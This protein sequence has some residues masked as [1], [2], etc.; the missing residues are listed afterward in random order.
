[1][2]IGNLTQPPSGG[3]ALRRLPR[4]GFLSWMIATLAVVAALLGSA[5]AHAAVPPANTSI[6]N[7]ANATYQDT[8]N[9]GVVLNAKSNA[10]VTIVS[11]VYSLTLT[12]ATNSSNGSAGL[13]V[14]Y[15]H[16]LTNTGNGSDTFTLSSAAGTGFTHT[17]V[18]FFVG[19]SGFTE[20]TAPVTLAPNSPYQFRVCG[21]PPSGVTNGATGQ[22]VV[23][24]TSSD[25]VTT[26]KPSKIATNTT[27]ISDCVINL[28]KEFKTTRNSG[29]SNVSN[30]APGDDLF[31]FLK[32]SN[33][34]TAACT[35]LVMTDALPSGLLYIT[36]SGQNTAGTGL[37]DISTDGDG[38]EAPTTS[39]SGTVKATIAS[40]GAGV[41]GLV[42]FQVKVSLSAPAG[43]IQNLVTAPNTSGAAASFSV[44]QVA[45]VAFN[46]STTT[47]GAADNDPVTV[48]AAAPG[49]TI[50]W[51]NVIW[52][53]GNKE[54][55]FKVQFLNGGG[56]P[57][58][59]AT[60]DGATCAATNTAA[61]ACT[62]PQGTIFSVWAAGS[63]LTVAPIEITIPLP[64]PPVAPA[65]TPTCPSGFILSADNKS[66]GYV[67]EVRAILPSN[68]AAGG[69]V[70]LRAT[71]SGPATPFDNVENKLTSIT[72]NAVDVTNGLPP[73]SGNGQGPDDNTVKA[74]NTVAP[75][76]NAPK[77]TYFDVYISNTAGPAA[78]YN[79]TSEWV[80]VPT[81]VGLATPPATPV[82]WT[83]KFKALVGGACASTGTEITST[84]T[85]ASGGNT[86]VCAEV[87][88]PQTNQGGS[89]R[90][91]DAPPGAYV[92]KLFAKATTNAAVSDS[93]RYQVTLTAGREVTLDG[94]ATKTT[95]KNGK[96]S[97]PHIIR[98]S[99]NVQETISFVGAFLTN[100]VSSPAWAA[101]AYNGS[102]TTDP[103]ITNTTTFTLAPN[104]SKTLL[105]SVTAPDV[106]TSPDNSTTLTATY[107]FSGA[108]L[109][110]Q[111]TDITQLGDLLTLKKY[112]QLVACSGVGVPP[113]N[114]LPGGWTQAQINAGAETAPGKCIA[115]LVVGENITS[116]SLTD[117]VITD[118]ISSFTTFASGCSPS[119]L[120]TGGTGFTQPSIPPTSPIT[121]SG[122]TLV[123]GASVKLQYCVKING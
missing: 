48:A 93:I 111:V 26:P 114:T 121:T 112:Q 85:V 110:A 29:A 61:G 83:I 106:S 66:C 56:V 30:A 123:P 78:T 3:W 18:K 33:A 2:N 22:I 84:G 80:S 117:I 7:E 70:F 118:A 54:D 82:G 53:K 107:T 41:S 115:Y 113:S 49:T 13:Q 19:N 101:A 104:E 88:I 79:L 36:G 64:T 6:G 71:S 51:N 42:S 21:T 12:P 1:M 86:R 99:G 96:V 75:S 5:S 16:T 122:G 27:T 76:I 67:V 97:N 74:T 92:I 59:S 58:N 10:V 43:L 103:V 40:V 50:T 81:G 98:N 62:L 120:V 20:I 57:L 44:N 35:S 109:T 63:Q 94:T 17:S 65:T 11:Q 116:A 24:A 31:V 87:T 25:P 55:K 15:S 45:L 34:G 108:A 68:A 28:T 52:N 32:Y 77:Q 46:G 23:T 102:A 119:A 60:F 37:T 47:T 4:I 69:S 9:L 91:T 72:A 105:V 95:G 100:S 14:C 90:P 8:T 89:G 73:N 38:Y 39:I